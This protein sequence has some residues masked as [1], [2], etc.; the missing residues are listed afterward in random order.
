M[1]TIVITDKRGKVVGTAGQTKRGEEGSGGPIPGPGEKAH[2]VELP[3]ALQKIESPDEL[4]RAL[5]KHL[6]PARKS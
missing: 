4:H 5:E 3:S 6:R 1:K 2:D